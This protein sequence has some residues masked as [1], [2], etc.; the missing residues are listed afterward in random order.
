MKSKLF[1]VAV[2]MSVLGFFC[3]VATVTFA[4]DD[5]EGYYVRE[6]AARRNMSLISIEQAK[7]IACDRIGSRQVRFKDIDLED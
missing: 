7:R 6:E 1:V 2:I 5:H 4:N 3:N